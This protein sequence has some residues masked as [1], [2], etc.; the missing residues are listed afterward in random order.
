[1]LPR[2]RLISGWMLVVEHGLPGRGAMW[3]ARKMTLLAKAV[4]Q[5]VMPPNY[6]INVLF[7][8]MDPQYISR[9][10]LPVCLRAFLWVCLSKLDEFIVRAKAY[11]QGRME[12]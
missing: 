8:G 12:K 3:V 11:E 2:P 10:M 7:A 1:M 4:H 5:D 6:Q 9:M